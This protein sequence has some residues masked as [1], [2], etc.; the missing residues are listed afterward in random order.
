MIRK[1]EIYKKKK[2]RIINKNPKKSQKKK[3]GK[4]Y[5][6]RIKTTRASIRA[7]KKYK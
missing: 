2:T 5:R 7:K 6:V 1:K 3:V 4:Y